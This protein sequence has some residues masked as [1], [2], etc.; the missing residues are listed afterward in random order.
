MRRHHAPG[1]ILAAAL[2]TGIVMAYGPLGA[3][4]ALETLPVQGQVYVL[5]GAAGNTTLQVGPD[6]VL[7][8]DPPAAA[9][10][11]TVMSRVRALTSR[12]LRY[13]VLTGFA[14]QQGGAVAQLAKAGRTS[15]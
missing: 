12:D 14:P 1:G 9:L 3:Q 13:L 11:D 2:A 5:A 4:E 15:G 6:G 10:A 8:V 7:V